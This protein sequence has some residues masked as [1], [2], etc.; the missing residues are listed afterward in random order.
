MY[1][2]LMR[3]AG[4]TTTTGGEGADDHQIPALGAPPPPPAPSTPTV[5]T[6][7]RAVASRRRL[8]ST[9]APRRRAGG[10]PAPRRQKNM[11]ASTGATSPAGFS[12]AVREVVLEVL[13]G[14]ADSL[15]VY[16]NVLRQQSTT[17]DDATNVF[18]NVEIS[19]T[20]VLQALTGGAVEMMDSRR[21]AAREKLRRD[22]LYVSGIIQDLKREINEHG[23]IDVLT[24]EIER[25]TSREQQENL[26]IEENE[27]MQTIVAELRK[28]IADR[29]TANEREGERL[30]KKL[31]LARDEKERLK[32]IKDAEMKY[33]RVWEAA[34]REQH[35]LRYE[36]D[37]DELRR[38]LNDHCVRERNETR[39]ND[40]LTRYLT[41][42]VALVENRIEQ[43][44][45]R[46]DREEKVYEC[47]IRRVRSEIEDA[48]KYL[49]ELT[50][51]HRNN[52]EF[53][54]T[55]LAEQEALRR[56]KEHED[57]VLRSTIK[58]QA[59]WRGV[60][61]RRKLGPYRPE[62]KKKKKPIKTKR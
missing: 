20:S 56:Q 7:R 55:Y 3:D 16:Q 46:Y 23:T 30:T 1:S 15:A 27:R 34:R 10:W 38:T 12:P 47:E 21:E 32:L 8:A 28:T 41:R 35:V 45:Q 18:P 11:E 52:Q 62:E 14:C 36:S 58:M 25:I 50:T 53:I 17:R 9:H 39:V 4:R 57:H 42:R 37:T 49:G 31:A 60:M 61:V 44:R 24:K 22:S 6:A 13:E 19:E 2:P 26:L 51:E 5:P 54:D 40:V 29:K 48:R 43:W 59:W 33:V